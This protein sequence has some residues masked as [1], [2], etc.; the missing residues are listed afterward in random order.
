MPQ[1]RHHQTTSHQKVLSGAR[2][3][4][5]VGLT[6]GWCVGGGGAALRGEED[7][8]RQRWAGPR[9]EEG[10]GDRRWAGGGGERGRGAQVASGSAPTAGGWGRAYAASGGGEAVLRGRA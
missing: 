6:R 4:N 10:A 9:S 1:W 2:T 8:V 7:A 5:E 3:H